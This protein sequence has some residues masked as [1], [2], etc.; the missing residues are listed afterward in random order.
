MVNLTSESLAQ[1]QPKVIQASH[2]NQPVPAQG[3]ALPAAPCR[4]RK[5]GGYIIH[6]ERKRNDKPT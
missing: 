5:L 1:G 3:A 4:V 2:R 6:Q